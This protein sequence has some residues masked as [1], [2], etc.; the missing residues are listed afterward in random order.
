MLFIMRIIEMSQTDNETV[1]TAFDLNFVI[2][3]FEEPDPGHLVTTCAA[4]RRLLAPQVPIFP[5]P[6]S[7]KSQIPI[8]MTQLSV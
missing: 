8:E 5:S 6:V 1:N 7:K 4:A 3:T 2:I